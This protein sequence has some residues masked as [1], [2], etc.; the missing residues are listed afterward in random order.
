[1]I[2]PPE[3]SLAMHAD[4]AL[5]AREATD[6]ERHLVDCE[7][8]RMRVAALREETRTLAAA[9]AYDPT[10]VVVPEF[11][12]PPTVGRAAAAAV[13]IVLGATLFT[14][15]RGLF[16]F[17][18]P[19]ALAWLNPFD[20]GG[21]AK[22]AVRGGL[23]LLSD[24]SDAIVASILDTAVAGGVFI[25]LVLG[26]AA[27]RG[28]IRGPF[29]MVSVLS[30]IALQPTPSHA[31]ELRH[32]EKGAVLVAADETVNDSLIAVGDTVEVNGNVTGD[33]IAF[34]RRVVIRGNVAGL[35]IT[36]AQSVTLDGA[37]RGLPRAVHHE[38]REA[39][40]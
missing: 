14:A 6:L 7:R 5:E 16:S 23:F 18:L 28:R 10:T 17:S 25:L 24:Q 22:L 11:A 35:V 39:A 4:G 9:L 34:G 29:V 20:A 1:M 37:V 33:L 19:E 13:A 32:N 40:A 27:L 31:L 30:A 26:V 38:L 36:G 8:C 15:L 2:C 12:P 21:I 3:L